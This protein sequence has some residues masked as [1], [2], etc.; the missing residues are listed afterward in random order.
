MVAATTSSHH[1]HRI[2][3]DG[4]SAR[5]SIADEASTTMG[6]KQMRESSATSRVGDGDVERGSVIHLD[7]EIMRLIYRLFV[8]LFSPLAL[9]Y[10]T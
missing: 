5:A 2:D 4:A 7:F 9:C 10:G 8:A 3:A 1:R 6:L